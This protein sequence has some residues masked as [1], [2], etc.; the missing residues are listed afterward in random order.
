M[1]KEYRGYN[2]PKDDDTTVWRY[3]DFTKYVDLLSK[4]SQ[5]FVKSSEFEDPF[6]GI[7]PI[8]MTDKNSQLHMIS[9]KIRDFCY[10]N[11]WH[12]NDFESAAMWNLYLKSVEGIAIKTTSGNLKK[13]FEEC[14]EPILMSE[15]KYWDYESKDSELLYEETKNEFGGSTINSVIFKRKSFMHENELR[16]IYNTFSFEDMETPPTDFGKSINCNLDYLIDEIVVAPYAPDW[17][18]ELVKEVGTK[19]GMEKKIERS[20]LYRL[21]EIK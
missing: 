1:I 6:E 3:M 15:V 4:R 12:M 19:Y 8:K 9:K 20:T 13:A 17:F 16:L 21:P 11:C 14:E 10:V 18:F 2:Q 7:Y 5:F